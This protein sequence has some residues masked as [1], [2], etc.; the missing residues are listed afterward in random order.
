MF[1]PSQATVQSKPCD[2][3]IETYS[4]SSS[5]R[6]YLTRRKAW[7]CSRTSYISSRSIS[8]LSSVAGE[9]LFEERHLS[10]PDTV[11]ISPEW[12]YNGPFEGPPLLYSQTFDSSSSCFVGTG[13]QVRFPSKASL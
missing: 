12:R 11:D 10:K 8:E 6:K 2:M 4:E 9:R 1:W 5:T 3:A 7:T 13:S